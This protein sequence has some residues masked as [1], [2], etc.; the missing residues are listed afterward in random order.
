MVATSSLGA[1]ARVGDM[2]PDIDLLTLDGERFRLSAHRRNPVVITFWGT[3][4]ESCRKEFPEL[5]DVF[6]KHHAA[7]LKVVGV[8]Q[9]DQE[10][11][12]AAVK[13]FVDEMSTT[14][15]ILLDPRGRTRRAYRLIGL[16]TTV[17]IDTAGII[18]R[19]ITGPVTPAQL[20]EG[21][22]GLGVIR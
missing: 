17:F 10:L 11:S 8:N 2:A 5:S 16:P 21:L 19:V 22:A 7:G 12:T 18:T 14:F 3:W 1:Q 4:C 13:R 9:R 20:A 15:T 6:N